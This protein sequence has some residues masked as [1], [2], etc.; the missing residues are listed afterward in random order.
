M[1]PTGQLI[2]GVL[3]GLIGIIWILQGFDQFPGESFA[4]GEWEWIV[5]GLIVLILGAALIVLGRRPPRT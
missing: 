5:I 3:L 4:T 1:R 2:A